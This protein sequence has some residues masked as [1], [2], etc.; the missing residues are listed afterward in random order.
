VAIVHIGI[1]SNLGDRLENCQKALELLGVKGGT[2]RKLSSFYETEP[3]GVEDQPNFLNAAAEVE[4]FLQAHELLA[5]LKDIEK[6]IGRVKTIQWGPRIIDLD[7]LFYG[8]E[9]IDSDQLK[10]P[11]PL[12]HERDF[13]LNPLMEICPDKIHPLK[14]KTIKQLKEALKGAKDSE[15]KKQKQD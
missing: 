14:G 13:V 5:I 1:G 8:D 15:R 11:H 2:I 9:V 12:L 7:I 4:T 10:I 6:V 3:W